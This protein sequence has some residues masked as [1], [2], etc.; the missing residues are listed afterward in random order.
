MP[1]RH[2]SDSGRLRPGPARGG[3]LARHLPAVGW[4]RTYAAADLPGDLLAGLIV[5]VLLVPQAMAY[6]QLADLPPRVGLYAAL[7]PP[8]AYALLGSSRFLAVGPVALVSLM[9]G[10]SAPRVA[11][12]HGFAPAEAAL[13]LAAVAGLAMA[14]MGLLRLGFLVEFIS[15]PVLTGFAAAAALLIVASQLQHLLGVDAPR[16]ENFSATLAGVLRSL[17][18]AGSITLAVGLGCL[19]VLALARGPLGRRLRAAGLP[20]RRRHLVVRGVP[21][22]VLAAAALAAWALS[23][24]RRG[25][26]TVGAVGGG[27]PRPAL[28][29]LDPAL[30]ADLTSSALAIAL[31]AFVTA[32]AVSR[33]LGGRRRQRV[34]PSQELVGLGAANLAAAVT[35]GYPV[36]GSISRSV[37]A[38]ETGAKTPL[39]GLVAAAVVAASLLLLG[40]LLAWLPRA[41]LAALIVVAV[42][43]LIDL[44]A[45]RRTWGFSR[46][47]AAAMAVTF[48]VTLGFGVEWGIAVG[49]ATGLLLLL[50]RSSRPRIAVVGRLSE[51]DRYFRSVDRDEVDDEV[52]PVLVLRLDRS[53]IFANTRH[54]EDRVLGEVADHRDA[55]ALLLDLG[56]VNEIDLS[57]LET[58]HRLVDD[59]G[60]AGVPVA[61]AHVKEPVFELLES[62]G[63]CERIGRERI[64]VSTHEAVETIEG[65]YRSSS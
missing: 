34:E 14:V 17:P 60:A 1:D 62:G 40:P 8:L 44:R 24:D 64:F 65:W 38:F 31:V 20:A 26:A 59:L 57:G 23:L 54:F 25:L 12:A 10:E 51:E 29:P 15:Q 43:G 11:A 61:V 56:S 52:S 50:W 55:R 42:L 22:A 63:L 36:G 58:L 19:A 5:A 48:V 9:V 37:V 28:P 6:A 39:A 47:D 30:W 46:S 45:I 27:L 4:L 33:S 13:A 53:L 21:L 3:G 18:R 16:G 35:G 49:A 41:A 7:V 32:T 2:D